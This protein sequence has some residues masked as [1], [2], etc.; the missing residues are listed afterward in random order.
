MISARSRCRTTSSRGRSCCSR[1]GAAAAAG[2][3]LAL[4]NPASRARP[5]Q[6]GAALDALRERAA[7]R[8]ARGVRHRRQPAGRARS[9]IATLARADPARADMRTLV[10]VGSAATRLIE[11]PDGRSCLYTPRPRDAGCADTVV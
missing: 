11:R 5:W 6:L 10:L 4:Y 7:R 1:L 3:V 9:T 2:F 8:N